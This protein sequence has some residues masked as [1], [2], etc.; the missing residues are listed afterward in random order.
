MLVLTRKLGEEIVIGENIVVKVVA[1][2]G[3]RVRIGLLCM[4]WPLANQQACRAENGGLRQS[5]AHGSI[6]GPTD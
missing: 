6:I 4:D 3:D 2:Q 1:V 5:I